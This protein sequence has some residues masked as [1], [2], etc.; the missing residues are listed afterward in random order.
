MLDKWKA[1]AEALR[2]TNP[3]SERLQAYK[4]QYMRLCKTYVDAVKAHQQAKEK[5]RETQTENLVR[6][7]KLI[8]NDGT[9]TESE[10]RERVE[11]DPSGFLR[12]AVMQQ[13]AG[14]AQDAYID[15]QSRARDVELLVRS[16]NEVAAMFQDLA[17][18]VQHQSE[19]L[20]TIGRRAPLHTHAR[21]R[22]RARG[23]ASPTNRTLTWLRSSAHAFSVFTRYLRP[24]RVPRCRVQRGKR[25]R[26]HQEG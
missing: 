26:V 13:A 6:R 21:A 11:Q 16:I 10:I 7:G 12:E 1:D 17:V 8:Y 3:K 4:S 19:M 15:A 2:S 22:A 9:K 5:M 25:A 18:L 24:D 23:T 14:A 20:D